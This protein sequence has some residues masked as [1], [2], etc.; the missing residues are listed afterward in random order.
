MLNCEAYVTIVCESE[1]E[2]GSIIVL[3]ALGAYGAL[4][5][6]F[7]SYSNIKEYIYRFVRRL[8]GVEVHSQ[9]HS[10][11]GWAGNVDLNLLRFL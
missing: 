9:M 3:E 7:A 2:R 10:A 11:H 6:Q 1:R 8:N 4:Y 5:L